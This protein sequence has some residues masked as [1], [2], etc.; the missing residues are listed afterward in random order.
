MFCV[1]L[2]RIYRGFMEDI[3]I[4][5]TADGWDTLYVPYTR[6]RVIR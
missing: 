5:K 1:S 6:S 4:E 3:S 2:H